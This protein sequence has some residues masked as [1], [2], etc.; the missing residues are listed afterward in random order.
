MQAAS[1]TKVRRSP[2]ATASSLSGRSRSIA[3]PIESKVND[4]NARWAAVIVNFNA[5][6]DLARCIA[7]VEADTSAG[8][9]EIVVVDNGSTDGSLDAIASTSARVV[10]SPGNVGYARAA[11]LG[12]AATRGR[13][14][15]VLNADVRLDPGTAGAMCSV[16]DSEARV[17]AVAPHIR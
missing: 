15:A 11:N 12:I 7:S 4:T 9:P 17:A 3:S 10:L 14:V 5:G 8:V 16:L 2:G 13:H 6:D 1:S